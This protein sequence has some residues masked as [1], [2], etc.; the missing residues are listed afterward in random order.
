MWGGPPGAGL[1]LCPERARGWL[2]VL[3][4]WAC[5][6]AAP[7]KDTEPAECLGVNPEEIILQR[8][9]KS[10]TGIKKANCLEYPLLGRSIPLPSHLKIKKIKR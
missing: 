1:G 8:S 10:S 4:L 9:E 2:C 5:R 3:T 7:Y 6:G